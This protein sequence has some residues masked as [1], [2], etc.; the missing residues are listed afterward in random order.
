MHV[1]DGMPEDL[2]EFLVAFEELEPEFSDQQLFVEADEDF[3]GI[4]RLPVPPFSEWPD[5]GRI[6][7]CLGLVSRL[8]LCV[9]AN[10]TGDEISIVMPRSLP[11]D[12]KLEVLSR[13]MTPALLRDAWT[14]TPPEEQNPA[15][16]CW[17][18]LWF[19]EN[20][21]PA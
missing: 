5:A 21:R 8:I 15:D 14:E 19:Y 10:K 2:W 13:F 16:A 6:R 9:L 11:L 4:V 3:V 17:P 20:E 1:G 12:D 18:R 7:S